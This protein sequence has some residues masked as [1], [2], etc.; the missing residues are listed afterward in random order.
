MSLPLNSLSLSHCWMI[1]S[2]FIIFS[3]LCSHP[4]RW[5][6]PVPWVP[7]LVHRS[8][9][10]LPSLLIA[11]IAL[12]LPPTPPVRLCEADPLAVSRASK[13]MSPPRPAA[14]QL[15]LGSAL[16]QL[17][18]DPLSLKLHWAFFMPLTPLWSFVVLVSL[19]TLGLRLHLSPPT[20]FAPPGFSFSPA[21]PWSSLSPVSPRHSLLPGP[22]LHLGPSSWRHHLGL[23]GPSMLSWT[24]ALAALL[25]SQSCPAL[26]LSVGPQ[27]PLRRSIWVPPWLLHSLDLQWCSP[28]QTSP[29]PCP[30][31]DP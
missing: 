6:R 17:R 1:Q 30:S 11:S 4:L 15:R 23:S 22:C 2:H 7:L 28:L 20:P 16:L 19:W 14:L 10:A 3:Q 24:I 12:A 26:S 5:L 25:G 18:C 8:S 29:V 13:P 27:V 9:S 31:P 21:Q